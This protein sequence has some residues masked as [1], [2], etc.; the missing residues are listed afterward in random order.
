MNFLYF[1]ILALLAGILPLEYSTY[2]AI[3]IVVF[4]TTFYAAL[5]IKGSGSPSKHNLGTNEAIFL[6]L[7]IGVVYN[8]LFPIYLN[9]G[10]WILLDLI[11]A[12]YIF[13]F[14]SLKP[15]DHNELETQKNADHN[16]IL[17]K[18]SNE[19]GKVAILSS[20][21]LLVIAV[22]FSLIK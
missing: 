11:A 18:K 19:F 10:I 15:S 17:K 7:L 8:P 6:F 9:R 4:S 12:G 14:L 21:L 16:R 5:K 3:K 2:T 1:T 20:A 13:W 22:F